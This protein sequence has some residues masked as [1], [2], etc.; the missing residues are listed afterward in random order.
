MFPPSL[1]GLLAL[2]LD[3]DYAS[4]SQFQR[5]NFLTTLRSHL[6]VSC[7]VWSNSLNMDV[8][9]SYI[10]SFYCSGYLECIEKKYS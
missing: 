4:T 2:F 9:Y 8:N 1:K 7:Y 6:N 3:R 5:V 10:L